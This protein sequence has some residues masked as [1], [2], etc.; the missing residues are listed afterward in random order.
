M[1]LA[2]LAAVSDL[3]MFTMRERISAPA[4][5]PILLP[6]RINF[7]SACVGISEEVCMHI[8]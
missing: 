1:A 4:R 7:L 6:F 5:G 3:D 2:L 8:I